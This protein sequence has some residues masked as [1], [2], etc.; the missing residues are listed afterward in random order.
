MLEDTSRETH[1]FFSHAR[2]KERTSAE[3][4]VIE[5]SVG[6]RVVK[7]VCARGLAPHPVP[8]DSEAAGCCACSWQPADPALL[9]KLGSSPAP[10]LS[11]LPVPAAIALAPFASLGSH[12]PNYFY[13]PCH[14]S[15]ICF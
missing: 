7:P 4:D 1:F 6:L 3:A 12:S 14:F 5:G 15:S 11:L 10:P 9:S 8:F 13:I 2:K